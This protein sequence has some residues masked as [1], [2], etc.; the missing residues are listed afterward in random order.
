VL[1]PDGNYW[2]NE[3]GIAF[4]WVMT[5]TVPG[6]TPFGP[7]AK[8]KQWSSPGMSFLEIVDGKVKREV[9]YHD[10]SSVPRSLGI[11]VKR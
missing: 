2:T 11:A 5:A 4:T 8:G 1:T 3:T 7:E 10:S 6:D 9:D